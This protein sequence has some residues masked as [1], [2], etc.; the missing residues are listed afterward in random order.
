MKEP[1]I[2]KDTGKGTEEESSNYVPGKPYSKLRREL[3]D[4][5][6]SNPAVQKLLISEIDKLEFRI[7][8]LE[9]IESNFH[10]TDKEKAVLEVKLKTHN[11]LE[12]L[13]SFCLAIGSGLIGLAPLF[14]IE[15][16]GWI[17]LVAGGILIVGG[18][19]SKL[20]KKW[21]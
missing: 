13:Y 20:V 4:E 9:L 3:A 16:K 19:L 12:V 10:K 2:E 18:I 5:D 8:E 11:S 21:S 15:K 1:E 17:F 6:L 14:E 7:S